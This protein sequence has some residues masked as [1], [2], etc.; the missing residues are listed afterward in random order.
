MTGLNYRKRV[1]FCHWNIEGFRNGHS[2]K[3]DDPEFV[4]EICK[5]DFL[6]LTET[7]AGNDDILGIPGFTTVT[8]C[9]K[10][11]KMQGNIRVGWLF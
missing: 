2:S 4:N 9:R 10:K 3:F 1:S 6:G 8:S 7:H 11:H 5:Y